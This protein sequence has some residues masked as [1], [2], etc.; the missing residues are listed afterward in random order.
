MDLVQRKLSKI[1]WRSIEIPVLESDRVILNLICDGYT[2]VNIRQNDNISLLSILKIDDTPEMAIYLY[3]LYFEASVKSVVSRC[4]KNTEI[5]WSKLLEFSCVPEGI[6]GKIRP[7]KKIDAMRLANLGG[8]VERQRDIIVEFKEMDFCEKVIISLISCTK[9]YAL[10]L[11]TLIHIRRASVYRVNPYVHKYVDL[12]IEIAKT[13][14]ITLIQDIVDDSRLLIECN[15]YILKFEDMTLYDHQKQLFT[16]FNRCDDS[17]N[18]KLVLYTAPTGT[19]KTL[20]P[21]GLSQNHRVL[22]V[23]AARHV[24]LSLARAA[25]SCERCVAFA[26]G[27][28][29]ACD[30]RLHYFA[31]SDYSRDRR[32]GGIGKVDNSNGS[33]VDIMICDVKSYLVAMYY[34]LAF[35]SEEDIIMYW[36]EPTISLDYSEHILHST[37]SV[38]WR[39]NKISKVVL[40]CA[41]L[42]LEHEIYDTIENF[43]D[44]FNGAQV[45]SISSFDCKKSISILDHTSRCV[46]PHLL[47]R[48]Y[49]ELHNCIANCDKN[50]SLLRYFDL[51]EIVRF[52]R[53]TCGMCGSLSVVNTIYHPN[54]YFTDIED[55]TM[56]SLKLYYLELLRHI[57]AEDWS[58]LHE[59]LVMD[60]DTEYRSNR[61][62]SSGVMITTRDAYTITDGP[63]IFLAEDVSK[64]GKF[65]VQQ[66]RLPQRV[67]DSVMSKISSN[68]AIQERIS[69]LE[70]TLQDKLGDEVS[71]EK[72]ME[73]ESFS[74]EAKRVISAIDALRCEIRPASL[75]PMYIPNTRQHQQIWSADNA[76]ISHTNA[77]VPTIDEHT[78]CEVMALSVD[79]Q[80]KLLMLMGIGVF[81]LKLDMQYIELMKL[82]A[83]QEKLFV[84]IATSDYIYGT[85]Y[86]FCHGFLGKDL[87]NMTQQKIIQSIGRIG[88]GN[89]Q[90]D[91]TIRV[92]DPS[93]LRRLFMLS[94]KNMEAENMNRL[95]SGY[96]FSEDSP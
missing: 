85:N 17:D 49:S 21:L 75:D 84:V 44:K 3:K 59:L 42:P 31:A 46:L 28:E 71:K 63:A 55:I 43:R 76:T 7:I 11:Y 80:F 82:M 6:Y 90:H 81:S 88:R 33:R 56:S 50:R 35:N 23:C 22:F 40:S 9:T 45:H 20:S 70:K 38:N 13:S 27:C 30:I 51:G 73:K 68:T 29:T 79:P 10:Y 60:K 89:V 25:I 47:F 19:G 95:F 32:S 48:D 14:S 41:T 66:S 39:E 16:L 96:I 61:S 53:R 65:L 77:F 1:E 2:N 78:V 36:D 24:G 67:L 83:Y 87:C 93:L 12:I 15:P 57:S 8:S 94:E 4:V 74:P 37:I 62:E 5:N 86:N 34:M 91:Y 72:K 26:F 18:A 92:R 54:Y 69:I 58:N 64:I 52:I